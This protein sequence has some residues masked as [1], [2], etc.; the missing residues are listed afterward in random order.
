MFTR[1]WKPFTKCK[2]YLV[3]TAALHKVIARNCVRNISLET[4]REVYPSDY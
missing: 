3:T 2:W 1:I 4:F